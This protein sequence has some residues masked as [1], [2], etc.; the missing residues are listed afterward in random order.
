VQRLAFR[1]GDFPANTRL[2]LGRHVIFSD[3]S[4][5]EIKMR[6]VD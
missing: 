3:K 4:F 1:G 2:F 6:H 5:G